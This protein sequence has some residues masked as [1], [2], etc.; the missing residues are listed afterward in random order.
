MSV[1][2]L[3]LLAAARAAWVFGGM[4]SWNDQGFEGETQ[5]Q[6]EQLSDDLYRL[7]NTAI[8]TAANA[9]A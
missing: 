2:S 9:G 5:A 4:G 8:V 6:Y 7:L 1:D 3:R